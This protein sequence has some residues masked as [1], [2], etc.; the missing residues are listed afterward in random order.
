MHA[1]SLIR[2]G[3]SL[4]LATLAMVAI[5]ESAVAQVPPDVLVIGQSAEPKSMDPATVTASN[6]FRI[7]VNI[8]DGLVGYEPGT[9]TPTPALARSWEVS[10]D[11]LT[12]TFHL[13]D[14]VRFHDGTPFDA[15]AVHFNFA[16]MLEDDH[17]FHNTG[18]FPLAFFFNEV[19]RIDV[20]D[21]MTVRFELKEP[22]APFLSNLAYPT[23]LIVSPA[24]VEKWGVDYGR[25]PSGTGPFRFARWESRRQVALERSPDYWGGAPGLRGVVFRP[26]DDPTARVAE[27]LAGNLDV[28][29]EVPPDDLTAFRSDP[30]FTVEE[31]VGPHLWFLILNTKDGPFTEP[32]VRQAV[33]LAVNKETLTRDLLQGTAGIAAGPVPQAF[34]WARNPDVQPYPYDPGRAKQLLSEAGYPDGFKTVFWVA[35]GGSGM[36]EPVTMATAIQAD[37]AQ[38]GIEATIETYEWNA[39]LERVNGGLP[40]GVG[41][42]EMAWMT[43]DPDTLPFLALRSAAVPEKGGFNSGHYSNPAMDRLIEQGRRTTDREARAGIYREIQALGHTDAPWAFIASWRQNAV[44]T[45][46]VQG[47]TLEPSFL[48][49]LAGVT[50]N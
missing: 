25:H 16:R 17:P 5:K 48:L 40:P 24:A 2:Q 13:R 32:R 7:L 37:L 19:Q 49:K 44:T 28:M 26:I 4:W 33:N 3:I 41:M 12:Y 11:G 36:L 50:K 22:F 8:Y 27:M 46:A 30:G 35:E 18:P 21:P 31:A 42:A 1:R 39:Y 47:L 9:L 6:D 15:E 29:V 34:E 10:E 45:A 23:G 38:V 14:G 20:V 43:N